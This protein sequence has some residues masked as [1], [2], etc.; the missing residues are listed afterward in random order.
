M[1]ARNKYLVMVAM[2]FAVAMMSIDQTI[3]ALAIPQLQG[4]LHLSAV[5]AQWIVNGYLIA[6]AATFAIGGR[7]AD[8][9]GHR[10]VL[11][12]GVTGFAISS[13]LCGA[14]PSGSAAETWMIVFR[15]LQGACAALLFP[16]ALATVAAA[17][18]K[19]ERGQALAGFF[20]IAG[21]LTAVGPIA[22][23]Y[24]TEWTWRSIFWINVPIAVIA[25]VFTLIARPAQEPQRVR[26]DGVGAL[27]V[28]GGMALAVLGLQQASAW[29]WHSKTLWACVAGGA[30][31]LSLFVAWELRRKQDPLI[32][33]RLFANRGYAADNLVLFLLSVCFVPL[34]FFA[35]VYAQVA[36]GESAGNAGLFLLVFFGGFAIAAQWGGRALDG[37]GARVPVILGCA[38]GAVG[39]YLWGSKLSS[40][41]LSAQ[42]PYLAMAGAGT[43]L[44]LGP[45]STDAINRAAQASYG[46]V[47]GVSQTIRNFAGSLGLAVLGSVLITQTTTRVQA[48]LH[49][50]GVPAGHATAIAHEIATASG[51]IQGG[52]QGV[53]ASLAHA[54][55]LDFAHAT[56]SV[57]LLMALVMAAAFVTALVAMPR[58]RAAEQAPELTIPEGSR[59]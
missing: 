30:I 58:S 25:I 50:A 3:V 32:P 33:I 23:G 53:P 18:P 34:F 29:G 47:A 26:L 4:D 59:A 21:A 42:W 39:F 37:H 9:F 12:I 44:V 6:L 49:H 16:A 43:G 8:I 52:S 20:S 38:V 28:G 51:P 1:G 56:H 10:R 22:G 14:T 5:G 57:V 27:L 40:L 48:T 15:V 35:S 7:I 36:I 11:L 17:Y 41:S 19:S 55:A 45:A 24:L 31:L 13:A 54:I 46:A 2:V